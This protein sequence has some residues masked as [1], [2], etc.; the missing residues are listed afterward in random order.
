MKAI[1]LILIM[2]ILYPVIAFGSPAIIQGT[3]QGYNCVSQGRT[4]PVGQEDPLVAT[5]SV[6]VVLTPDKKFYF[7]PNL[8]R[9][10]MARHVNEQVRIS[11]DLDQDRNLIR[12]QKL[13]TYQN[14]QWVTV[15][16]PQMER[17]LMDPAIS[18]ADVK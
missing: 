16:T 4:C 6:F 9:A 13:E 11:G 15:W 2:V 17:H 3:I 18:K 1:L 5:E 14:G 7:F 8:D 10:V 12:A